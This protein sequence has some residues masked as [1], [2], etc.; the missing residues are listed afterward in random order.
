MAFKISDDADPL[1]Q[2]INA[3]LAPI[4][5]IEGRI[6]QD[7]TSLRNLTLSA[8]NFTAGS[9][10]SR[11]NSLTLLM[12]GEANN[13]IDDVTNII[14]AI[15]RNAVLTLDEVRVPID[16][17]AEDLRVAVLVEE[18]RTR[19]LLEE[20]KK[21]V[22]ITIVE[23]AD[24]SN[25]LLDLALFAVKNTIVGSN[26]VLAAE[27]LGAVGGVVGEL[28]EQE[29]LLGGAFAFIGAANALGFGLLA[30]V[31]GKV[32]DMDPDAFAAGLASVLPTITEMAQ[33][34]KESFLEE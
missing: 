16:L 11:F 2:Q 22:E 33:I 25:R 6:S 7:L 28:K 34:A 31:I 17:A 30:D 8:A 4:T 23:T 26:V 13:R 9:I 12:E 19:I 1:L 15:A 29:D 14:D 32:F 21:S 10:N 3:L 24:D 20:A 18:E 5:G 27:I